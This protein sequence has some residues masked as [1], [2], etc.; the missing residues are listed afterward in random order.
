MAT[1]KRIKRR[2]PPKAQPS[3]QRCWVHKTANVHNYLPVS[4]GWLVARSRLRE[5]ESAKLYPCPYRQRFRNL[6]IVGETS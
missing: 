6:S 5:A 3:Q 2:I 1:I 4:R